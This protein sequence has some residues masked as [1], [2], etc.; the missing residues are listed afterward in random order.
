VSR[1]EKPEAR[2]RL[3]AI[4][5]ADAA[6]Y[7]RLMSEDE[8]AT[9]AAL[10]TARKVFRTQIE[11]Q[12]GRVVDTAGD[13]VLASFE[14]ATGA[15]SAALAIQRKLSAR[16]RFRIGVH[17]G[18]V[19][20]KTDGSVYSDGV[21][22]S[23]R[24]QALCEPGSVMISHAVHAAVPS[25]IRSRFEDAGE[26]AV[27]N[28][29]DPVRAFRVRVGAGAVSPAVAVYP[30]GGP[31]PFTP[32]GAPP[33]LLGREADLAALDHLL[34]QHHHVTV[35]GAGGIGKTSLALAA[36]HARRHAQRDG[37]AWVDLSSISE[38][39]FL[40]AVVAQSLRL[41]VAGGEDPLPALVAGVKPLDVLLVLDNAEHLIEDVAR[42][43]DAVAAGAPSVHVLVTSQVALRVEHERVFRLGALAIPEV[44]TSAEAAKDYGA[45]ALFV[46]RA[47][48][49][50]Q[51]FRLTN[52][53]VDT[54][55][56]LCRHLDGMA[57][58]IRLAAGRLPLLGLQGL[59]QRL[60]ERLKLL[61]GT[62]RGAPTRQ[63]TLRAALDWS[64]SLLSE[65][66]QA[67]F[68]QLGVFAGACG[69]NLE[70]A[71]AMADSAGQDEWD[72]IEHISTLLDRSLVVDDGADPPRYRLLE[73]AREYAL[74]QLAEANELQ[75]AHER[76]ARAM[77]SVLQ[78]FDQG[79]WTTPDVP[80]LNAFG[81][82][83]DNVRAAIVWSLQHARQLALELVGESTFFYMLHHLHPELR[84]YA[85]AIEPAVSSASDA[86]AAKYWLAR[87][88]AEVQVGFRSMRAAER[89]AGLFRALGD[90]RGV[91]VS[92]CL[93]GLA[94]DYSDSQWSMVQA[95]MDSLA[96][97][98]WQ[99]PRVKVRRFFADA[100]I[101]NTNERFDEALEAAEA[102][103]AL[104]RSNG[105]LNHAAYL[106]YFASFDELGLGRLEDAERRCCEEIAHERRW[107]GDPL[108]VIL[109]CHATVLARQGRSA[110]ARV[111]LQ[112]FFE[113][114]R[115]S[116]W[117][118]FGLYGHTC[119]EFVLHEHRYRDAARLLGYA[120]AAWGRGV[121]PGR[122][123]ERLLAML[124]SE[125]DATSLERLLVEG[126]E[127]E[128]EAVCALTLE[129][130][131]SG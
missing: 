38:P 10:D 122:E 50:D 123:S 63:Q 108:E 71:R 51:R 45:V 25:R 32:P 116:G 52:A 36:A 127:L 129:I 80:L 118:L 19:L 111:A 66:E 49:V 92:L 33:A 35:L 101:Y 77:I 95:E 23:A 64:Y 83:L 27:K 81:R 56:E 98:V 65:A 24:L 76:F 121:T 59:K 34:A 96:P 41:P 29:A 4:L 70:L 84:R 5:A 109:G 79:M 120:R 6:G 30:S 90:E 62:G 42:L 128:Q 61:V 48:A 21:N 67:T 44:G 69:F 26:H 58:A 124:Q 125:I 86:I 13:S 53:N 119:V 93:L 9:L 73:S 102:G 114:S 112:E 20:E 97:E 1:T 8:R 46:D 74:Q 31:K 15:V 113:A 28:I 18:D 99:L 91:A 106:T 104:A 131:P 110:E 115:R 126:K 105:F 117:A 54:V 2:H 68:R 14:T 16:L 17:L 43:A 47:Q 11:S 57:L 78:R 130:A 12:G 100:A 82:E 40:C 94:Q 3:A 89:A 39:R 7:S 88:S 22:V 72:V 55:I 60:S 87:G 107:R 103:I 85:E 75:A 37:A